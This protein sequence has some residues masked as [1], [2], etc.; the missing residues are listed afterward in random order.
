MSLVDEVGIEL[1]KLASSGWREL[2]G[3]HGLNI[4]AS[5]LRQQLLRPLN[6]IDRSISGF[7]DFA[8]D[9]VRAIEPGNPSHSLLYHALAS[10]NVQLRPDGSPLGAAQK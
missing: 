1:D 5:N 7:E 6:S 10:P 3:H 4:E 2:L 8:P 9:G